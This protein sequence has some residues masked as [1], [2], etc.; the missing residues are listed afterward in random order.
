MHGEYGISDISL[1]MPAIVGRN[2]V[3]THI[4]IVLNQDEQAKLE[5][6]A[7]TLKTIAENA[8]LL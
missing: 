3:E 6:S 7:D 8:G 2:G 5:K 4:P 1:S